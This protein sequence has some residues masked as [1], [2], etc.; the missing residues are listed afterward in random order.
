MKFKT[1][2]P[3]QNPLNPVYKLQEVEFVPPS[4]PKF[5]R[6]GMSVA[7]IEGCKPRVEK[8]LAQR[9]NYNISDIDGAKPKKPLTRTI[10]HD[11]VFNDVTSKRLLNREPT[12]P[13]NPVYKI[14][15]DKGNLIDY[16]EITGARPKIPYYKQNT[17][18]CDM[19]LKSR[20]IHGNAPGTKSKGN[21]HLRDRR[22]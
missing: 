14:R 12:N 8:K 3:P 18:F 6:D 4:P 20:D 7:D 17:E 15:D 19:A 11:Q 21:F 1:K 22:N 16:G 10:V 9:D 2:R 13:S 5:I